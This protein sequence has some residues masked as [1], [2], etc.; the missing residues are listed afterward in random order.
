MYRRKEPLIPVELEISRPRALVAFDLAVLP[1]SSQG[2]RYV[3]MAVDLF[4]KQLEAW[5]LKEKDY[6]NSSMS[7]KLI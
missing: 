7:P 2:Y 1:W 4:S 6:T 5:A 3:L